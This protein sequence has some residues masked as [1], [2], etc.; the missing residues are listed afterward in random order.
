MGVDPQDGIRY[1][2]AFC[3]GLNIFLAGWLVRRI[4][5]RQGAGLA[6]GLLVLLAQP[7]IEVHAWAMS[8]AL[9]LTF[10]LGCFNALQSY[11]VRENWLWLLLSAVLAGF[12]ALT[13]YAGT[14][15]IAAG[16]V[17]LV[18]LGAQK[19]H[20]R[21]LSAIAFALVSGLMFGVYALNDQAASGEI[22]RF[23]GLQLIN[24]SGQSLT[25]LLYNTLLWLVPGRLVRGREALAMAVLGVGVVGLGAGYL[26]VRKTTFRGQLSR[27]AAAPA[28]LVLLLFTAASLFLLYQANL[29][30]TYRSPFDFRLLAPTHLA[31]LLLACSF[32]GLVWGKAPRM[33]R[34]ISIL[35]VVFLAGLYLQRAVDTVRLYHEEGMGFS[36]RYWHESD[37]IAY[38]RGLPAE[39][40]LASTA[41]M[42]VYFASGH[43]AR[44]A[45]DFSPEQLQEWLAAEHGVFVYF[46]SMPFDI[47]GKDEQ[48][49]LSLLRL[50][51]EYSDS[52]VYKAP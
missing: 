47:Y 36:S 42:G 7:M 40:P 3:F 52:A 17:G 2:N 11:F 1:L 12:A 5:G 23:G 41:P 43:E 20:R 4:S 45:A 28:M 51:A 19:L 27:A 26:L 37:A 38:L 33:G 44:Q 18:M 29:S 15:L 10:I 24:P 9:F 22:A 31:S 48:T 14:A 46:R 30:N 8:E 39:T 25:D 6:A 21:L 49:Y 32:F 16:T 34:A 13:R 50:A 35:I